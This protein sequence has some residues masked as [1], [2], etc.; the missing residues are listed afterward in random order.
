MK[1][2]RENIYLSEPGKYSSL[3]F[4]DDIPG[5]ARAV[6][7][8]FSDVLPSRA[9]IS[10]DTATRKAQIQAAI[11]KIKATKTS[12]TELGKQM[13]TNAATLGAVSLPIGFL[14]ATGIKLMGFRMPTKL[15]N[16]FGHTFNPKYDTGKGARIW[17]SPVTPVKTIGKYFKGT[18]RKD[19]LSA[20]NLRYL[21]IY[22][23]RESLI[24]AGMAAVA[25]AAYPAIT[26]R[27][28]LSDK[29]LQ[30][31]A[32]ILQEHPYLTSLPVTDMVAAIEDKKTERSQISRRLSGA[33]LGAA[34]GAVTGAVSA[35]TPATVGLAGQVLAKPFTKKPLNFH[36]FRRVGQR[37]ELGTAVGMMAGIGAVT[38]AINPTSPI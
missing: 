35:Y 27:A 16:S 29:N 10:G 17:R 2:I 1:A 18:A 36:A 3:D 9:I 14:L 33:G 37:R 7:P 12:N 15:V 26:H 32:G 28:N 11:E 6:A 4:M 8:L 25:G 24:G 30:E 34:L 19:G 38:G 22:G 21:G 5:P 13:L 20:P 31:A 23:G